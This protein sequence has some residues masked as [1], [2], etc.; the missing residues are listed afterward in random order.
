MTCPTVVPGE[1]IVHRRR[2]VRCS[3]RTSTRLLRTTE[4]K[5]KFGNVFQ[6]YVIVARVIKQGAIR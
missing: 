4:I 3:A 6:I 5:Q 2:I 1:Y